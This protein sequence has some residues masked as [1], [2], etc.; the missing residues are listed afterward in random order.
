MLWAILVSALL[1]TVGFVLALSGASRSMAQ[2]VPQ[3]VEGGC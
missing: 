2:A 1:G 3:D